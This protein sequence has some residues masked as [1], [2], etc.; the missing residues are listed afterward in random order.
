M[1]TVSA[2]GEKKKSVTHGSATPYNGFAEHKKGV[3]VP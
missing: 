1:Y 3:S 2:T